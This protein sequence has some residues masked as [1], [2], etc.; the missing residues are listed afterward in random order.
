MRPTVNYTLVALK[1]RSATGGLVVGVFRSYIY[2]YTHTHT[3]THTHT[4]IPGRTTLNELPEAA[5]Y[6]THNKHKTRTSVPSPRFETAI[7]A[8]RQPQT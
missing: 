1:R 2:I 7:P 8:I 3:D 4:H 6:T 5:T